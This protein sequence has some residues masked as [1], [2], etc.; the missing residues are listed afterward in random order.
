MIPI[1]QLDGIQL[2]AGA[3]ALSERPL[4]PYAPEVRKFLGALAAEL[5]ADP[6]AARMPDVMTF[7][8]W[9]RPANIARLQQALADGRT[10]LG[11]G[12][13]LHI[14]PSNVPVNFAFSYVFGLLA[15]NANLVRV[16]AREWPEITAIYAAM[17][18]VFAT[19]EHEVVRR[20][21]AIVRYPRDGA[22]TAEL[23][24]LCQGRV[25]WGGDDTINDIRALPMPVRSR[26]IAFADRYSLCVLEA[27][28]ISALDDRALV[29]LANDFYNDTYLVDQNACSSAQ[30]VVWH[31]AQVHPGELRFWDAVEQVVKARYALAPVKQVDK[32]THLLHDAVALDGNV[33]LR[34]RHDEYIYRLELTSLLPDN[35]HL[36]GQFG[37]FYEF[38]AAELDELAPIVTTRYQTLSYFGVDRDQLRS[39][40]LGHRL[41]GI[42]HVVPVGRTLDIDVIWDGYDVIRTLSR[43]VD[44]R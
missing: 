5:R 23:S 13:V 33:A 39:L 1:A 40:V 20:H 28:A 29:R 3:E 36:R 21:T 27:E 8:F 30:L 32:Y 9:I 19:A 43:I 35:E 37:Y 25:I 18:R 42:D 26:E 16:P 11:I 15:G 38:H 7:A 44:I 31:G 12:L 34:A 22:I 2:L 17:N 10:R 14:A 4:R 41:P 6:L 24:A